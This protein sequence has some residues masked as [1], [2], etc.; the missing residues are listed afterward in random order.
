MPRWTLRQGR[1]WCLHCRDQDTHFNHAN[2]KPEFCWMWLPGDLP[3]REVQCIAGASAGSLAASAIVA[4][5]DKLGECVKFCFSLA[6]AQENQ[7]FGMLTPKFSLLKPLEEFLHTMLPNDAHVTSSGKLF[8]SLTEMSSNKNVLKSTFETKDELIQCL[9]GSSCIP[10]VTGTTPIE[11]NGKKYKDGGITDNL[12]IFKNGRT[13]RV[14]P[15][16]GRQEISPH[17]KRGRGWYLTYCNEEFQVNAN[18]LIRGYHA[19][20]PPQKDLM[21]M[22]YYQGYFDATRF[23]KAENLYDD[24]TGQDDV[25]KS[26]NMPD[27][28]SGIENCVHPQVNMSPKS[29]RLTKSDTDI[30]SLEEKE[31]N[32]DARKRCASSNGSNTNA[33]ESDKVQFESTL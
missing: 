18:N 28:H 7:R 1:V 12:P 13:I 10:H 23:L 6:E 4:G 11:I 26:E 19:F 24:V 14:T 33:R 27:S 8:V 9:L 22:Y 16:C 32:Q 5:P 25:P 15:F 3:L 17:D 31:E 30:H 20:S 2:I 29:I 21:W